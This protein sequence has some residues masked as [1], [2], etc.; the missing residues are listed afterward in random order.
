[1]NKTVLLLFF[2]YS[3]NDPTYL[4]N[5]LPNYLTYLPAHLHTFYTLNPFLP[6]L[7]PPPI[8]PAPEGYSAPI[9]A[10][11]FLLNIQ[12]GVYDGR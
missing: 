12:D 3:P 8:P 10:A 7:P 2:S 5:Y 4:P 1:M 6:P 9:S 11:N